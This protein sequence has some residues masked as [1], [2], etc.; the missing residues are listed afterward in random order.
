VNLLE[1]WIY[2]WEGEVGNIGS[3][4]NAG[5]NFEKDLVFCCT[6]RELVI[7]MYLFPLPGLHLLLGWEME[8]YIFVVYRLWSS[9]STDR[10]AVGLQNGRRN[11]G[12]MY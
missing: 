5:Q 11:I 2:G 12:T 8:V 3:L 10:T 7:L 1:I 4:L 9:K 6:S